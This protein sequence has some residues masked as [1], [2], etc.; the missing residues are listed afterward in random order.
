MQAL[1]SQR[2]IAANAQRKYVVSYTVIKQDRA[3]MVV[4]GSPVELKDVLLYAPSPSGV[5][6]ADAAHALLTLML[7][8]P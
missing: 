6:F 8:A 2:N 1:F 7:C 3:L 4:P 5:S